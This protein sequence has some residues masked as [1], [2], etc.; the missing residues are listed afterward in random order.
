MASD[1]YVCVSKL[2]IIVADNG[3]LLGRRQTII[4][5][6]VGI[7]LIQTLKTNLSETWSKIHTFSLKKMHLKMSVQWQLF[8]L[9]LD[10]LMADNVWKICSCIKMIP[11]QDEASLRQWLH[12]PTPKHVLYGV[13][14]LG[15]YLCWLISMVACAYVMYCM[16]RLGAFWCPYGALI[17]GW[18]ALGSHS[19]RK[20]SWCK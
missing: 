3:F 11:R 6:N 16:V 20:T 1:V 8:C 9:G 4:W 17:T 19:S 14:M 18:H 15:S 12:W 5:T 13:C 7:L 10:M 2:T